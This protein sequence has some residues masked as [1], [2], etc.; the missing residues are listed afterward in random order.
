MP[1]IR[2][3]G[4]EDWQ[5]VATWY[6][7]TGSYKR[8]ASRAGIP[9]ATVMDWSKTLEWEQILTDVRRRTTAKTDAQL[10]NIVTQALIGVKKRL[11]E[12]DAVVGKHGEVVYKPVSAKDQATIAAIMI[13]KRAVLGTLT[14]SP[15]KRGQKLTDLKS[16]LEDKAKLAQ[17]G[18]P[19]AINAETPPPIEKFN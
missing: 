19:M 4:I 8:S 3:W 14:K 12:G 6:V 13:D 11:V 5:R 10:Q 15:E 18:E 1:A 7:L 17:T 2:K 9:L 16:E